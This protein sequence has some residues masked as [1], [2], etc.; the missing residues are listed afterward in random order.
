MDEYQRDSL[1][2]LWLLR[3][4]DVTDGDLLDDSGYS[5]LLRTLYDRPFYSVIDRDNYRALDGESLRAEYEEETGS[6]AP[7][8][9]DCR[10]LEM[11]VALSVRIETEILYNYI[12]GNRT[13][14][15]FWMM[16]R[17]LGLSKYDDSHW[18]ERQVEKIL[19]RFLDREYGQHGVGSLFPCDDIEPEKFREMEIWWQMQRFLI[20]KYWK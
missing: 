16:V 5:Y 15:W 13:S 14:E 10:I 6:K 11:M 4:I 20:K 3:R 7:E 9:G 18:N 1:Y 12:Y 19:T 17:N 8:L 2:F